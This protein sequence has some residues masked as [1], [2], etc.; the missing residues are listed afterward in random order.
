VRALPERERG[1]AGE[2]FSGDAADTSETG[3]VDVVGGLVQLSQRPHPREHA[4]EQATEGI[5]RLI[6]PGGEVDPLPHSAAQELQHE[7]AV[8]M[9]RAVQSDRIHVT[10]R[11][12]RS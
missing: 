4:A 6:A 10:D 5:L 11:S 2:V 9:Q 7:Q 3:A 1:D 12:I 8:E